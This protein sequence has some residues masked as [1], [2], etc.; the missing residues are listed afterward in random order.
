MIAHRLS[1]IVNVD[2]IYVLDQ[3]RII[4]SGRH[5]ELISQNGQYAA[6]WKSYQ[7]S[8]DWKVGD[9]HA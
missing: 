6:M 4:E 9:E 5:A 3:G 1:T 8:I 7:E 2:R